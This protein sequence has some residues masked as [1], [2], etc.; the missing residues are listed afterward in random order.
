MKKLKKLF[1]YLKWLENQ[2]IKA[3]TDSGRGFC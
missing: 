2:K 1:I 3:M